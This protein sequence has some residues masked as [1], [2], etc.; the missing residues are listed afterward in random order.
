MIHGL[1]N[2]YLYAATKLKVSFVS[3]DKNRVCILNGTGFFVTKGKN[4]Y[5]ITNRHMIDITYDEK[6]RND[7]DGYSLAMIEF[8][9]RVFVEGENKVLSK[10]YIMHSF[11]YKF[12]QDKEDDIAC[13]YGILVK[14]SETPQPVRIPYDMLATS[15]YINQKLSVCDFVAFVGFPDGVIDMHNNMPVLRSGVISSDPRLD[16]NCLAEFDGHVIAYEAFST[17]G[18]SGSPVFALQKGFLVKGVLE[19]SEGFYREPKLIGINAANII[20]P[21][22]VNNEKDIV[23]EHQQISI[24]YKSN[25][26]AALIDACEEELLTAIAE[27]NAE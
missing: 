8:D 18:A 3:K 4:M 25:Y 14:G 26:I 13:L 7:Y 17:G 27:S 24:M 12:A 10:E 19:A 23:K 20:K 15:D 21:I 1:T 9:T 11:K 16:Y 2:L 6:R 5:L 22:K